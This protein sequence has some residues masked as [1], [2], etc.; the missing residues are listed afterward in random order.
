MLA[1]GFF[2]RVQLPASKQ[3][4]QCARIEK[5]AGAH[6]GA[7]IFGDLIG[8]LAPTGTIPGRWAGSFPATRS[9]WK[10]GSYSTALQLQLNF[11]LKLRLVLEAVIAGLASH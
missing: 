7:I 9:T 6:D 4:K 2:F 11:V 3:R 10:V 8:K 5:Q 1:G